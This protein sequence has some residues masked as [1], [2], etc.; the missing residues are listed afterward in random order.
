MRLENGEIVRIGYDGT[1]GHAYTP[2][3]RKLLEMNELP[4]PVSMEAIRHWL[5]AHPSRARE[6]MDMNASYVFFRRL[7]P[8]EEGP[9]GA[10]KVALTPGRSLAVDPSF[11]P[12]GTPLWLDTTMPDGSSF[13]HLMVAQDTGGAI[14]G[15]IRGDIFFGAGKGEEA[16]AGAMQNVGSVVFLLPKSN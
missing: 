8:S 4:R 11:V 15:P 13:R 16:L 12:L 2:I 7:S 3:G 9:I 1:N 5:V 14:K 10:E 6:I